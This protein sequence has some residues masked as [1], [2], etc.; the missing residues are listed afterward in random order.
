VLLASPAFA[1]STGTSTTGASN[2]NSGATAVVNGDTIYNPAKTKQ[3]I[4]STASGIAPGLTAAGVHSC[5]GSASIGVGAVGW[6]FGAGTTYEMQECNRRAYAATLMGMGQN[7]AALA[8]VCNNPEV[9]ASLNMTGVVCPQQRAAIQQAQAQAAAAGQPSLYY[10]DGSGSSTGTRYI[11]ANGRGGDQLIPIS[12]GTQA[13]YAST[14]GSIGSA[15][16]SAPPF[17]HNSRTYNASLCA[18]V[19]APQ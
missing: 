16:S 9:Q 12:A 6:N 2:S 7:A 1:Q 10:G 8:L 5:A 15:R 11:P 4:A 13:R 3:R 19:G 18:G 17:C 14:T